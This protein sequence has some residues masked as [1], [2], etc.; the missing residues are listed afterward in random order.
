MADQTT[1][2]DARS[3][4]GVIGP[5]QLLVTP[6]RYWRLVLYVM[7]ASSALAAGLSFVLL[8]RYE[9]SASFVAEPGRSVDVS[10][11][12]A[13]L[14]GRIRLGSIEMGPSSP[15]FYADLLRSRAIL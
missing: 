12:L 15:Q 9:V 5:L 4:A 7:L 14:A 2:V 11:R 1:R 6:A 13:T 3:V 8:E 10:S